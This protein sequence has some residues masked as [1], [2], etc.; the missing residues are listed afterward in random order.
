MEPYELITSKE[1]EYH[2]TASRKGYISRKLYGVVEPYKGRF[3]EG[4]AILWPRKDTTR[5]VY[6]SY[7]IRKEV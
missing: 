4:Y 6:I 7:Y 2:H 5:F 1:Y 3:G